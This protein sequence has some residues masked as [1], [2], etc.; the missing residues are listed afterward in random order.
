[1]VQHFNLRSTRS[2]SQISMSPE[3]SSPVAVCH[4]A[5]QKPGGPALQRLLASNR[6]PME[7]LWVNQP[8][9]TPPDENSLSSSL[10]KKRFSGSGINLT[11]FITYISTYISIQVS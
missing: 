9:A 8:Q 4:T 3:I 7:P 6:Q 2:V 1:M 5:G 10:E 11:A